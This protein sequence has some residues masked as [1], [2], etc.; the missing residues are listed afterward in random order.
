MA[1]SKA[2]QT[3]RQDV[4]GK[5]LTG[6]DGYIVAQSLY[7]FIREQQALP[8]ERFEW[9]NAEDAK[10]VLLTL[11]PE[12]AEHFVESDRFAGRKPAELTLEKYGPPQPALS[13][14][15]AE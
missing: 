11:F 5:S 4:G 15:A 14:V 9:S 3:N 10:L 13:L 8:K 6:R 7:S 2:S 1:V 12:L